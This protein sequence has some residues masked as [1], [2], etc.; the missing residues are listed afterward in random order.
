MNERS[1][2]LAA[3]EILDPAERAAYLDRA[4]PEPAARRAVEELLA[5]HAR[6]GTFMPEPGADD[7]TAAHTPSADAPGAQVGPYKLRERIGE[8]GMGEVWVAD[9][10]EPIKRRV[11]LKLVKPGMDSRSVLGRF[12]AERQALA[13]MDHPHIAKVLDAG[14]TP[15]GRPYFV[16]E[17]VKGTPITEFCDARKLTPRERLELFVPVCQAIQHAHQ[18]GIIH[19]D[20][21]P[22]NVLVELHD[23][24]M[25]PKVIDFGV[26][27]AVG[28]QLTEKTIYT[29][30]GALVGTPAYMAPEQ[31]AFNA[32]DIDTRADVYALGVLLYELLAG[33]PPIEKE[34]LKKAALDEVLRIVRDEEPPRPSQRLS[35]SQAKASIAATRQS[36]PAELSALMRGE[37]DWIVMKAL[38]NDRARRYDAASALAKDV[39]RYLKGDAVEACPPTLGYRLRKAY[40]R[41]RA[42]VLVG[43]AFAAVLLA[44]VAVSLTFGV[45]ANRAERQAASD[46][47]VAV[48]SEKAADDERQKAQQERDAATDARE[49]LRRSFYVSQLH[50]AQNALSAGEVPRMLKLLDDLRPAPG[51]AD[52]RGFEWHYLRN[53]PHE[54]GRSFRHTN[55]NGTAFSADGSRVYFNGS[56]LVRDDKPIPVVVYDTADG[57]RVGSF[58]TLSQRPGG[59]WAVTGPSPGTF[60]TW[61]ADGS[62]FSVFDPA[63]GELLVFDTA[64]GTMPHRAAAPGDSPAMLRAFSRQLTPDG[65]HVLALKLNIPAGVLKRD[66]SALLP[67]KDP[68]PVNR[69]G[70]LDRVALIE[71]E[72]GKEVRVWERLSTQPAFTHDG[73]RAAYANDKGELVIENVKTGVVERTV[74]GFDFVN[75]RHIFQFSGNGRHMLFATR[76]PGSPTF[77]F[78]G[79]YEVRVL[80][81]ETGRT[82][83][84]VRVEQSVKISPDGR[85]LAVLRGDLQRGH[86]CDVFDAATGSVVRRVYAAVRI[87]DVTFSPD[88][89][90]VLGVSEDGTVRAWRLPESSGTQPEVVVVANPEG[91]RFLL[92]SSA[93]AANKEPATMR[94]RLVDDRGRTLA[95]RVVPANPA[96]ADPDSAGRHVAYSTST[97]LGPDRG[98]PFAI[99]IRVWDTERNTER[100]V[101]EKWTSDWDLAPGVAFAPDGKRLAAVVLKQGGDQPSSVLRIYDLASGRAVESEP[102]PGVPD[103]S[104]RDPS[105]EWPEEAGAPIRIG[106]R[107]KERWTTHHY[108]PV[109]AKQKGREE[110]RQVVPLPYERYSFEYLSNRADVPPEML[111]VAERLSQFQK[112]GALHTAVVVREEPD[113]R[114]VATFREPG[115]RMQQVAPFPDGKRVLVSFVPWQTGSRQDGAVSIHRVYRLEDG[116]ELCSFTS[117]ERFAHPTFSPDGRR[118]LLWG[119]SGLV[120]R[121][122][123]ARLLDTDTGREMLAL[124]IPAGMNG[125]L[126]SPDGH[127]MFAM[128]ERSGRSTGPLFQVW[129]ATPRAEPKK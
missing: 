129:D 33:S 77:G 17:L 12:E 121:N 44:A 73:A 4:C 49:K 116:R 109:T 78:L 75:A 81:L 108:D 90:H 126:F 51:E 117:S 79:E 100:V 96:K 120:N 9:Q 127:R 103:S 118:V 1:V 21:K 67:P 30:Y 76:I 46:R 80:D 61:S 60:P 39:E 24:R 63:A 8:G 38:E 115:L 106:I 114:V 10:Q 15:D 59:P 35:T 119:G 99:D 7:S 66:P 54:E 97:P 22:S 104:P 6:S 110:P 86:T 69:T 25:V 95:S 101:G 107:T 70:R 92:R 41:N 29:G 34:R 64:T 125:V 111:A 40:R 11:A 94:L 68:A 105:V 113:G 5:A 89:Q 56:G 93:T 72:S 53:L 65:R 128:Q 14:A 84:P 45:T 98:K 3:L 27:K 32:L 102:V 122:T 85:R 52:L 13:L 112:E 43:G 74:T 18:K 50:L 83:P 71:L 123:N 20:I 28:H 37:L 87:R 36:G 23:D 19:R 124:D 58:T 62:R 57:R 26:A 31:A 42:A 91:T 2:F 82:T 16:M 47:D 55:F 48:A 88:G